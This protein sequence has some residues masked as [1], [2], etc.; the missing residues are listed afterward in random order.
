MGLPLPGGLVVRI[1]KD[2]KA[3]EPIPVDEPL[4][5]LVGAF[6]ALRLIHDVVEEAA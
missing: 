3:I 4:T 1:P 2:G 6:L 5:K